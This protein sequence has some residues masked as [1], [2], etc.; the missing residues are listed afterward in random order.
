MS[1]FDVTDVELGKGKYAKVC[2]GYSKTKGDKQKV[3]IKIIDKQSI[4]KDD[5]IGREAKIHKSLCHRRI[6]RFL[7]E[8]EDDHELILVLEFCEGRDLWAHLDEHLTFTENQ[9][10]SVVYKVLQAVRYLHH[11]SVMHRDLKLGA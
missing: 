8:F 5:N 3:A 4:D 6:C 1:A 10:R 9:T 7:T 2:L 11:R